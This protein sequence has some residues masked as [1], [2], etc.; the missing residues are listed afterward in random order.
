MGG[1]RAGLE[2]WDA[3]PPLAESLSPCD[4]AEMTAPST[5]GLP[6]RS[7][8]LLLPKDEDKEPLPEQLLCARHPPEPFTQ[9]VS[10]NALFSS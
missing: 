2:K 10:L 4:V 1:R 7:P 5:L 8:F 6:L 9:M 3:G